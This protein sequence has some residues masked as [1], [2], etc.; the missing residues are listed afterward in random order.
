M[1]RTTDGN[2]D[3]LLILNELVIEEVDECE[4]HDITHSH[5]S[6]H[7]ETGENPER[8]PG[9]KHNEADHIAMKGK[10][11][12]I[13]RDYNLKMVK[14][15]ATLQIDSLEE[16]ERWKKLHFLKVGLFKKL[17]LRRKAIDAGIVKAHSKH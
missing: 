16:E 6:H 13:M 11:D 15:V 1:Y 10:V 3:N 17:K 12:N 8:T 2:R 5:H 7:T 14:E 9:H 4:N